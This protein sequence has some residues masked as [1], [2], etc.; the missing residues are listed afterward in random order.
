MVII[1]VGYPGSQRIVPA[2]KYLTSKY[3]AGFDITYLNYKGEIS[4]WSEYLIGFLSYLEDEN[5]IFALDD[6]LVAEEINMV[7]FL[8]A[9][10]L[11]KDDVVCVKLCESTLEEHIEYPVT[12]Q[13]TIWKKEYLIWLLSQVE[14]PWQF[15][16][17]GSKIHYH[18]NKISLHQPCLRY[19]TN[20]AISSRWDGIKLDGLCEDDLFYIKHNT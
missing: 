13:F 9:E 4:G 11:L 17:N 18:T 20:S 16:I 10:R 6:Y 7:K 8:E 14:T 5:I 19:F 12:T 3:L 15:E 2:S 1:L